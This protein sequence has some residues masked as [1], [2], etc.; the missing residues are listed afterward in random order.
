MPA[1]IRRLTGAAA[2]LTPLTLLFLTALPLSAQFQDARLPDPGQLWVQLQPTLLNWSDQFAENS[3]LFADGEREPLFARFDGPIVNRLFPDAAPLL[4]DIN[5]DAAALGFDAIT[6]SDLSLGA[7]DFSV[8]NAQRRTLALGFELG[9]IDRLSIGFNAPFT[10]TDVESASMFD[11]L[12]ATVTSA[13]SA[14]PGGG[15]FFTESQTALTGLQTLIDGGSLTGTALTDAMLLRDEA[16]AFLTALEG[17]S[18]D[19]TLIPTAGSAAG[20]QMAQRFADFLTNFAALGLTLPGL[21]LPTTGTSSDLDR[22]FLNSLEAFAP[23]TTRNGLRLGEIELS[24]RYNLIDQITRRPHPDADPDEA[25]P[26]ATADPIAT[27]HSGLRLRTTVG[28][29]LRL[30]ILSASFPPFANAAN[31]LDVPIGDG[32]TDI[33]LA[34][35]QDL[36][37]RKLLV[38]SVAVY[39][40]QRPDAVILRVAPP[41]RPFAFKSVQ[42]P[43]FRDLGD[44][45]LVTVRPSLR[46]NSALSVGLEWEYFRLGAPSFR[47]SQV[48]PD[49]ADASFLELEGGQRRQRLGAGFTYDLSEAKD[50]E[51]LSSGAE[52]VRAPWQFGISIRV[53]LSGSGGLT[54]ASFRFASGFRIPL[55]K[56]F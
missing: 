29:T 46:L 17:R 11:S 3:S 27:A 23:T 41:D 33:E 49:V 35:Y 24:A 4:A 47:L 39:G 1:K 28:V 31:F 56:L 50:R 30:P 14:F 42:T 44:Y 38:R 26:T 18:T 16:D 51:S 5:A 34:L 37:Y 53:P 22:L 21:S 25:D 32:Q 19:G 9:V 55:G 10:V 40:I 12:S 8:L 7:L 6:E 43:V 48:L 52:Q 2:P 54:P 45:L 36:S 20:T 13:S 15:T